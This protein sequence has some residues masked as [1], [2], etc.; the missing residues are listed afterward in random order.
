MHLELTAVEYLGPMAWGITSPQLFRAND[1]RL[2]VVKLCANKIGVKAL[3]NEALASTLGEKLGLCFPESGQ[4]W[5]DSSLL[6][7][8]RQ[9]Q[10]IAGHQGPHFACLYLTHTAYVTRTELSRAVN[11]QEL[12]GVMLFDQLL[13][14]R[15]RTHNRKNLLIRKEAA[16][17]RIYAID[18]SHLFR[19][20]RWTPEVLKELA[21]DITVS[22]RRVYGLLLKYYLQPDDFCFYAAAIQSWQDEELAEVVMQIPETW[23]P[24]PGERQ[25]LLEHLRVR[26]AM[27]D[28]VLAAITSLIPPS[29]RSELR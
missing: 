13:H 5:L 6:K 19:R 3:A 14:N 20:G 22:T 18:H 7:R 26:R 29:R 28:D 24:D 12:A 2:Y 4:I 23:L 10:K 11:K 8:N 9:L 1:R 15:D 21:G 25:A 17:R 27:V 16:G